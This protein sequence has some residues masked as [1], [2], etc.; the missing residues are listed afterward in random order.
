MSAPEPF[1]LCVEDDGPS[2]EVIG[3]LLKEVMGFSNVTIFEDSADIL[4]RLEALPTA[5]NVVLLDIQMQPYD[6][7]EVLHM[8]RNTEPYCDSLIIAMTASVTVTD[9]QSLRA[10]GFNSLISKPIRQRF[11]P[12]FLNRIIAGEEVWALS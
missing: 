3:V 1:F 6:G 8:L 4:T 2:R 11:F 10:A 7:Y 9:I 5:P 12:D